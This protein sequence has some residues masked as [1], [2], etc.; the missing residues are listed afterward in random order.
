LKDLSPKK[1]SPINSKVNSAM[2]KK[3]TKGTRSTTE[4]SNFEVP[5]SA[6]LT[7]TNLTNKYKN[8]YFNQPQKSNSFHN[9]Q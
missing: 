1:N 3:H 8:G 6:A 9:N 5:K 4:T 7:E 2:F